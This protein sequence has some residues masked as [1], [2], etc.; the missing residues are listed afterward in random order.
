MNKFPDIFSIF[1]ESLKLPSYFEGR[2]LNSVDDSFY[3][4]FGIYEI[5]K[6]VDGLINCNGEQFSI[7]KSGRGG[8][9]INKTKEGEAIFSAV[10]AYEHMVEYDFFYVSKLNPKA[11]IFCNSI[12]EHK[13]R[14]DY[15]EIRSSENLEKIVDLLNNFVNKIILN[16][17]SKEFMKRNR[18]YL[19]GVVK[20]YRELDLFVKRIIEKK[21][22]VFV[23]RIEFGYREDVLC[24]RP[25]ED[26]SS[27]YKLKKSKESF[28]KNWKVNSAFKGVIAYIWRFECSSSRRL[29]WHAIFFHDY[30]FHHNDVVRLLGEYWTEKITKGSGFYIDCHDVKGKYRKCGIGLIENSDLEMAGNKKCDELRKAID[31]MAGVDYY[32]KLSLPKKGRRLGHSGRLIASK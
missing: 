8:S 31:F 27:Y 9:Y 24:P 4:V 11:Y 13:I 26:F 5:V 6:A 14:S 32:A 16:L 21:K 29:G 2:V 25:G 22:K 30:D 23:S 20:N 15:F 28:F 17:N 1:G 3:S 19:R 7:E 12:I 10:K 18:N